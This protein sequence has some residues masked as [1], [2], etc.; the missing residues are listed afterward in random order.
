MLE[1]KVLFLRNL[2]MVYLV[3]NHETNGSFLL[4]IQNVVEFVK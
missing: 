3:F 4:K 1:L 2:Q